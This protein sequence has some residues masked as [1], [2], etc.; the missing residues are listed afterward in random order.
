MVQ[1]DCPRIWLHYEGKVSGKRRFLQ[2]G[3]TRVSLR[4]PRLGP[5]RARPDPVGAYFAF[6]G[7]GVGGQEDRGLSSRRRSTRCISPRRE[8]RHRRLPVSRARWQRQRGLHAPYCARLPR[9]GSRGH[10]CE[11]SGVRRGSGKR[12]RHLPLGACGGSIRNNRIGAKDASGSAPH[13]HRFFV[14]RQR[15]SASAERSAGRNDA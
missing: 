4:A 3:H 5:G 15:T 10:S 12:P 11:S 7:V 2:V 14:E 1:Y 8:Q 6:S 9:P 13:R